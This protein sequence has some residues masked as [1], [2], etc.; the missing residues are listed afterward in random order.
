MISYYYYLVT[1]A[2]S[3]VVS[4]MPDIG[5]KSYT[6]TPPVSKLVSK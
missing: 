5:R 3:S 1:T 6:G 2:V 4:H